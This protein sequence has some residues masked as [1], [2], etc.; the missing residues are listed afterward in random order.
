MPNL[1]SIT[2]LWYAAVLSNQRVTMLLHCR[3]VHREGQAVRRSEFLEILSDLM[4]PRY[5]DDMSMFEGGLSLEQ[6]WGF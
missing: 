5:F 6:T 2:A 4:P 3:L 1:S